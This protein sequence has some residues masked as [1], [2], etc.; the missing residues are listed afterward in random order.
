M[1]VFFRESFF[2]TCGLLP[3]GSILLVLSFRYGRLLELYCKRGCIA[4]Y[5]FSSS[6]SVIME[7]VFAFAGLL[8]SLKTTKRRGWV[9][10][11]VELPESI[12]DHMYRMA[13]LALT[14]DT[15][16]CSVNREHCAKMALVHDLAESI[17]GDIAPCDNVPKAEKQRRELEAM[18]TIQNLLPQEAGSD[19]MALF[20]EYEAA[21]TNEAKFVK[22]L[23]KFDMILQAY[24]Y[25]QAGNR[26]GGLQEFFDSVVGKFHTDLV[27]LWAEELNVKRQDWIRSQ[28]KA[29]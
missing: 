28:P 24:E 15:T 27:K 3:R 6:F 9:L 1:Q 14:V 16:K 7:N 5:F 12:A 8:K 25:E 22:D 21:A 19:V 17:V 23:D 13:M 18:S 10:R 2:D 20:Q 26:P 4:N 11:G 29:E